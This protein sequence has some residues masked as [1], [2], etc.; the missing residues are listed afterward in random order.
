MANQKICHR[1]KC[2]IGRNAGE[3]IGT[4]TLQTKRQFVDR[5]RHTLDIIDCGKKRL[6]GFYASSN[7]FSCAASLLNGQ[8]VK[9]FVAVE[10]NIA[11]IR[12]TCMTSQPSPMKIAAPTFGCVACPHSTRC[13][14]SYPSPDEAM[15]QPVPCAKAMTPSTFDTVPGCPSG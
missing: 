11:F 13:N 2:G 5:D 9:P 8:S 12:P 6:D 14:A 10:P 4:A 1:A 3:P 15:P 7:R